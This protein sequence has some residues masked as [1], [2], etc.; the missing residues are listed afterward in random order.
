MKI[1][2][3]IDALQ[4]SQE[5]GSHLGYRL[6]HTGQH[7][8]RSM[9]GGFF[10]QLGIPAPD[11]NL[12]VG[13]GTQAAQTANIMVGYEWARHGQQPEVKTSGKRKGYKVFGAIEYFSGR[14]FY[15]GIEG[16]FNSESYQGFLQMIVEHTT[17]PLFFIH[18]GAR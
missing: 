10:E 5:R 13:S 6:I 4:A 18:A 11:L 16:R 9:S 2:P 12:E 1:A 3:I 14:L 8:D 15:Q 7:Y 17:Q